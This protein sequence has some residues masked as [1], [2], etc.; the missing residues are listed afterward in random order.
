MLRESGLMDILRGLM[1]ADGSNGPVYA[2]YGDLAYPQSIW[3]F[4]G[5]VNPAP[6][7][8]QRA[9]NRFMSG[10]RIAVEWGFGQIISQWSY[11]DFKQNM[12]IFKT[13]IA[14]HYMNCAFLCNLRNCFY[15]NQAT[16]YFNADVL[17]LE[18]YLALID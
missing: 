7:S 16:V 17:S 13:P 14:Q 1:P 3:L 12:K 15:G 5:Y 18:D 10:A 8:L 4:G 6:G 11:L 2:L 9:F